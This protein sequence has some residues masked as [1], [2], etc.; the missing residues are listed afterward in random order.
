MAG[1][2]GRICRRRAAARIPAPPPE[3]D[4]DRPRPTRIGEHRAADAAQWK[5]KDA[6]FKT[7]SGVSV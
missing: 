6:W 1:R 7:K 5:K 2:R 4:L 3:A